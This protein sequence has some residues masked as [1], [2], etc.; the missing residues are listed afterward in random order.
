[1]HTDLRRRAGLS[2]LNTQVPGWM[3]LEPTN[4]AQATERA[5][6]RGKVGVVPGLA[7]RLVRPFLASTSAQTVWRSNTSRQKKP[8]CQEVTKV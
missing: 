3:W 8:E 7:Y 6:R 5:L 1:M 2:H 4:V